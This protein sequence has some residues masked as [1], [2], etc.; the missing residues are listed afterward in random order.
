[1]RKYVYFLRFSELDEVSKFR[2]IN[3]FLVAIYL[4]LITPI[5]I[6]LQG[7]YFTTQLITLILIAKNLL[8]K[9][10]EKSIELISLKLF[11]NL[12]LILK[13]VEIGILTIY[14]Y[15]Q[16][17]FTYIY[18]IFELVLSFLTAGYGISL[19]NFVVENE[20]TP[21]KTIQI[22]RSNIWSEGFI[23]GFLISLLTQTISLKLTIITGIILQ[24]INIIIMLKNYRTFLN[25]IK[26]FS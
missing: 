23:I 20:L 21:I 25:F 1:M 26:K 14:F 8:N 17:Y 18:V 9:L 2:F 3:S 10:L 15:N 16:V 4:T 19:T 11:T 13:F 5:I 7:L 12:V 22:F 6:K 24:S